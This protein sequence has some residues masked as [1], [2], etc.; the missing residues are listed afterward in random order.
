MPNI[1][2]FDPNSHHIRLVGAMKAPS[3]AEYEFRAILDTGA[4]NTEFS[5]QFLSVVG[6]I[7]DNEPEI[8]KINSSSS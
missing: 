2:V 8:W 4:P 6:L 5:D 1:T 7:K 3:G